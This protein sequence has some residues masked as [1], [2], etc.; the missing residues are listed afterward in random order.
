MRRIIILATLL[1]LAM[2]GPGFARRVFVPMSTNSGDVDTTIYLTNTSDSSQSFKWW[3]I[4]EG[5]NG[6]FRFKNNKVNGAVAG[7][8]VLAF[9]PVPGGIGMI[10]MDLPDEILVDAVLMLNQTGGGGESPT[11]GDVPD[12]FDVDELPSFTEGQVAFPG[13]VLQI[14][15]WTGLEAFYAV[16][17]KKGS[18]A[19]CTADVYDSG[20]DKVGEG[21]ET[22]VNKWG[23]E[24]WPDVTDAL[25]NSGGRIEVSCNQPFWA[26]GF[27]THETSSSETFSETTGFNITLATPS[28]DVGVGSGGGG[29]GTGGTDG[30][31][32]GGYC[33][34]KDGQFHKATR[35]GNAAVG[36]QVAKP[37]ARTYGKILIKVDVRGGQWGS[38]AQGTHNI[39]WAAQNAR[40]LDMFGYV[41]LQK[42][43]TIMVR[44]GIGTSHGDK[45]KDTKG[46]G[47]Q[48]GTTYRYVY[49]YDALAD[50]VTV[51]IFQGGNR[52]FQMSATPPNIGRNIFWGP[53]DNLTLDF[54]FSGLLSPNEP[55]QPNWAW[56][57]LVVEFK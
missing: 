8:D 42:Q 12:N 36:R 16:N 43:N 47:F 20:N 48:L 2:S 23:I 53:D 39:F 37:P 28:L 5:A 38:P 40:N 19:N 27:A 3:W 57:N 4:P 15:A 30:C 11:F 7:D 44:H 31:E 17:M 6:K 10:G 56:S 13:D 14:H 33:F 22:Q 54:G 35:G 21:L 49:C 24:E 46:F 55:W 50:D 51:E 18:K 45:S 52:V 34:K 29:G 32:L 41:N 9:Q 26:G 1:G 25:P